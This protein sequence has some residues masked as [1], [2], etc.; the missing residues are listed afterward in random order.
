MGI[1]RYQWRLVSNVATL[2]PHSTSGWGVYLPWLTPAGWYPSH[3][4][5]RFGS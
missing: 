5:A 4:P 3:L 1:R 2:V